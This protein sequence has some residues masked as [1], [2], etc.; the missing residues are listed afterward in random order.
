MEDIHPHT[1]NLTWEISLK[2]HWGSLA[3][4]LYTLAQMHGWIHTKHKHKAACYL[5]FHFITNISLF[6]EFWEHKTSSNLLSFVSWILP[7]ICSGE[8]TATPKPSWPDLLSYS[9]SCRMCQKRFCIGVSC[10]DKAWSP[11]SSVAFSKHQPAS[12]SP[13]PPN[14]PPSPYPYFFSIIVSSL[15]NKL[16]NTETLTINILSVCIPSDIFA[17]THTEARTWESGLERP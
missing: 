5:M 15:L 12:F 10:K 16:T 7:S 11:L 8:V 3:P 14:A 17:H 1:G 6:H 4:P 9:V 13:S 2:P